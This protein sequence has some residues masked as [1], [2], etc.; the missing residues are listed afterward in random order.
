MAQKNSLVKKEIKKFKVEFAGSCGWEKVRNLMVLKL[1]ECQT[2]EQFS[3]IIE[4]LLASMFRN[5]KEMDVA[6]KKL[7]LKLLTKRE[8]EKID[9]K[10]T[11]ITTKQNQINK[12]KLNNKT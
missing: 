11:S 8:K 3:I 9:E 1:S 6:R 12:Q 7:Q 4:G 2:E 5:S 10:I